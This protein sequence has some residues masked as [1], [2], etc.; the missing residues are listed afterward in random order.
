MKA[1]SLDKNDDVVN[2]EVAKLRFID[3]HA[4][5]HLAAE[6][7]K[8]ASFAELEATM[9]RH[10]AAQPRFLLVSWRMVVLL[11]LLLFSGSG[12]ERVLRDRRA[13]AGSPFT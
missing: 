13:G 9:A 7:L 5:L 12:G 1:P 11:V 8:L 2:D 4:H 3:S 6:R 10:V